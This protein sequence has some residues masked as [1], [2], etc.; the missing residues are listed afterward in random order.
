M[1][2]NPP[3]PAFPE[4]LRGEDITPPP[5]TMIKEASSGDK[6]F[7]FVCLTCEQGVSC[8]KMCRVLGGGGKM[9]G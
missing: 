5:S 2:V 8:G 3:A 9:P 6:S 7:C 1:P 4:G